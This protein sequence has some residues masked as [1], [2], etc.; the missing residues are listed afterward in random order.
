M[1]GTMTYNNRTRGFTLIEIMVVVVIIGILIGLIA[2]NI[3]GRVDKARVTAAKTDIA[4][5]EQALEMYRLDNHAYPSTDQGLEALVIRPGGEPEPK[6]WNPEGYLKKGKLPLDP[7]GNAYQYLSPGQDKRPFDLFSFG[8]D[9]REG[10]EEYN[11][12]IGNW[13]DLTQMP[14]K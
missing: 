9:G 12:D 7:W 11:A 8:A 3:L 10:G 13:P 14:Q 2:P 6:N 4:T 5:L 1:N